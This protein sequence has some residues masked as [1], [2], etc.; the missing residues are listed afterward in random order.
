MKNTCT[1]HA[2]SF[3]DNVAMPYERDDAFAIL[4]WVDEQQASAVASSLSELLKK[5]GFRV[6]ETSLPD[7]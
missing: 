4:E 7:D 5:L 1:N 3:R 6:I 2:Q